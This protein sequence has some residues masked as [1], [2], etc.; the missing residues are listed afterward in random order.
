MSHFLRIHSISCKSLI[1]LLQYVVFLITLVILCF[2]AFYQLNITFKVF[3]NKTVR[4]CGLASAGKN[5]L[6][7]VESIFLKYRADSET[8]FGK[9][10][11]CKKLVTSNASLEKSPGDP[12]S[13]WEGDGGREAKICHQPMANADGHW[14]LKVQDTEGDIYN[15]TQS[16]PSGKRCLYY[17]W[18]GVITTFNYFP[19]NS[20][21]SG[22]WLARICW[23]MTKWDD[24]KHRHFH[25]IAL[26]AK[27]LVSIF[28]IN[29]H[30]K[31]SLMVETWS[32]KLAFSKPFHRW[33]VGKRIIAQG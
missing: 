11:S 2:S 28:G 26:G 21:S 20:K 30:W 7:T 25:I 6:A 27:Y 15:V 1:V 4:I 18:Y 13:C 32:F 10:G 33:D 29:F 17:Q 22:V 5:T 8:D 14:N 24:I 19:R 16:F 3:E 12:I 23:E 9:R 31:Q